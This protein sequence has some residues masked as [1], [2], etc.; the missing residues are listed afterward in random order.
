LR[1]LETEVL[2]MKIGSLDKSALAR[3]NEEYRALVES[4]ADWIARSD[5]DV[6]E[7]RDAGYGPLTKLPEADFRAFVASLEFGRGGFVTGS[8]RPLMA[9]LT[10]TDIFEVFES[11]GMSRELF[12]EEGTLEYRCTAGGCKFDFW[13]I[14]TSLC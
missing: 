8:Y 2:I 6:R 9:A 3:T 5:D 13:Q 4:D 1:G 11:F 12:L 10:L 14:C 7:I